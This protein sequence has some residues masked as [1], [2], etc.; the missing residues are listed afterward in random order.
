[1]RNS[2][3]RTGLLPALISLRSVA[4]GVRVRSETVF[5][6]KEREHTIDSDYLGS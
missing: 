1:M 4:D 3:A 6:M 5:L 2:A